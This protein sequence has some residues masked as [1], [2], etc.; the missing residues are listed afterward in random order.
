MMSVDATNRSADVPRERRLADRSPSYAR[1]EV[2]I[3]GGGIS[4]GR[5]HYGRMAEW[6]TRPA[7]IRA[8][9][10]TGR[11]AGLRILSRKG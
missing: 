9:G 2:P 4:L 11:R 7:N 1:A 5:R 8:S 3:P 10:E 6:Q